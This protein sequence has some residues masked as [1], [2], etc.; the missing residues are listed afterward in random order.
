MQFCLLDADYE[1][2][3]IRLFGVDGSGR[4]V[5]VVDE[6]EPY[7]YVLAKNKAEITAKLRKS[8]MVRR[9]EEVKMK[10]AAEEVQALKV[11]ADLPQ[12]LPKIRDLIKRNPAVIDVY[13]YTMPFYKRYLIDKKFYPFAW[14]SAEGE[15]IDKQGY[16]HALRAKKLV[17][18][19]RK[20][21]AKI[22]ILA[23]DVEVVDKEIIMISLAADGWKKVLTYKECSK[24][25][26]LGG[27][28][29]MLQ[30]FIQLVNEHDPD[31]IAGFNSDEFDFQVIRERCDFHRIKPLLSRDGSAIR[32]VRRVHGSAAKLKGRVHIDMFHFIKNILAPQLQFEAFT[33]GDAAGELLGKQK[34]E[35]SF[36]ELV[37]S[38]KK[39]KIDYLVEYSLKDAEITYDLAGMLMPQITELSR[40]SG[41]IPFDCSR[42]T[43]GLLAE[44]FFVRKAAEQKIISP[45]QPHWDE[46]QKRRLQRAYKGGY[47]MEPK[48]GLHENVA[49]FDFRSLY[50]SII[51]TF[52]ISPET[53]NCSCCKKN[54]HKVPE[55]KYHFCKKRRGFIP[56]VVESI[57]RERLRIK[58]M[59][60]KSRDVKQLAEQQHALKI[61][62]N[63]SYGLF[64][65]AGAKWY[66][67]ECAESSAAFGRFYIKQTIDHARK[68]G[69]DVLYGD[70]DSLMVSF[71][72]GK[73]AMMFRE[74]INKKLPG[75]ME[76]EL[77][78]FY[79]R[80]IFVPQ[81]LGTYAA[82]KRYALIDKKGNVTVRGFEAV[83]RDWCDL[84]KNLQHEVLRLVLKGREKEAVSKV[85]EVIRKVKS[86]K[87]SLSDLAI[88]TMLGKEL[89]E[90]KATG[91]HTAVARKLEQ[92]GHVI[93][94]GMVLSYIIT[95][96][97]GSI[98]EKAES[99]EGLGIDDYDIDY[100]VKNQ[101]LS[102]ALRVLQSLGYKESDFMNGLKRFVK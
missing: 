39:G 20:S 2:N 85:R 61:M 58:E 34:L 96:R 102:V 98:S 56:A 7:M 64:G 101:V 3:E 11:F 48:L 95:K 65:F 44:W 86:R 36:E 25:E 75:I 42:L 76:L 4:S 28:K 49:V 87:V 74:K 99:I 81:K 90:Y 26:V 9:I 43:Y 38:W 15:D 57:I 54:G 41:Q 100:Y 23:V 59:M 16:G 32:S 13:E 77:Q 10:L 14:I 72:G 45:N 69:F 24:A 27:E 92:Q 62:A 79:V 83:R 17:A 97:K 73:N 55:L 8:R 52:N 78:G 80:G 22:S 21:P 6:Y 71:R 82:K 60:K 53:L 93:R 40:V 29:E 18:L 5:L 84:S 63:A 46:I 50:P 88:R 12:N 47:V 51:V 70:T 33:L 91:P 68:E 1:G 67:R 19:D 35:M 66:C 30:R 89:E 94:P 31:V 37:E